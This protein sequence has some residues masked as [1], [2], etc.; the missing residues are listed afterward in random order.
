[1]Q[2]LT[3]F[4]GAGS[5]HTE[6]VLALDFSASEKRSQQLEVVQCQKAQQGEYVSC[7]IQALEYL[8]GKKQRF[9]SL[10]KIWN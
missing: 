9:D 10:K 5:T 1:M 8:I 6:K 7:C 3:S 4:N 2:Q